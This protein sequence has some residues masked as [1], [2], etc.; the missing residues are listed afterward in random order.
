MHTDKLSNILTRLQLYIAS[1]NHAQAFKILL[2]YM[3][4]ACT[5]I[6]YFEGECYL[7]NTA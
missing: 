1:F 6:C 5:V 4:F 7:G 3:Y 2:S